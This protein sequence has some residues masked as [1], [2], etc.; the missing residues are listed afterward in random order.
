M[1]DP[2]SLLAIAFL[3]YD[4]RPNHVYFFLMPKRKRSTSKGRKTK[5]VKK[6]RL[7]TSRRTGVAVGNGKIRLKRSEYITDII[8]PAGYTGE[9]DSGT[10]E[11][12]PG[13]PGTFAWLSRM[14]SLYTE[15]QWNSLKFKWKP[16]AADAVVATSVGIALGAVM[17]G[18]QYNPTEPGWTNKQEMEN[19]Q[20]TKS[21]KPSVSTSLKIMTKTG[22]IRKRFI[23][24]G[25]VPEGQDERFFDVGDFTFAIQGVPGAANR[26]VLGELHVE[27]DVTFYKPKLQ[28]SSSTT[29]F[30][31]NLT[32]CT[33]AAPLGTGGLGGLDTERSTAGLA[34]LTGTTIVF[35]SS[36]P[37]QRLLVTLS[38]V[39][40]PGASVT[41]PA[42]SFSTGI[43]VIQT[44]FANPNA[45]VSENNPTADGG[46]SLASSQKGVLTV[47]LT[48]NGFPGAQPTITVGGFA[49]VGAT[50]RGDLSIV[51]LPDD[52]QV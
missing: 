40:T 28:N 39:W 22:P 24:N 9:F 32:G 4:I 2:L 26:Y 35:P 25:P 52:N 27:Y 23:R 18:A 15:Y 31:Y 13:L 6:R 44:W 34:D 42:L 12:N 29:F 36:F 30:K 7:S 1:A 17:M 10:W 8:V 38:W 43:A 50:C 45:L 16:M 41:I 14:A 48:W 3:W 21:V 49:G 46:W 47:A 37:P 20:G 5:F 33:T 19:Y 11:L 51:G